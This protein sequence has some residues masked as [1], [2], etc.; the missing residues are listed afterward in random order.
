MSNLKIS[1]LTFFFFEL[2]E[3]WNTADK[4]RNRMTWYFLLGSICTYQKDSVNRVFTRTL[5]ISKKRNKKCSK[6]AWNYKVSRGT[7][8]I[9]K[10]LCTVS[11]KGYLLEF[12]KLPLNSHRSL[13]TLAIYAKFVQHYRN[14]SWSTFTVY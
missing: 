13:S 10:A 14:V 9:R 7:R 5:A 11:K 4:S 12:L 1:H 3:I 6:V 8:T 2:C